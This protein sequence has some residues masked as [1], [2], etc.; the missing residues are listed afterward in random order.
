MPNKRVITIVCEVDQPE[1]N[2]IWENH[3]KPGTTHGVS[4]IGIANGNLMD[5]VS[6]LERKLNKA[7]DRD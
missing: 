5:E 7:L 4:V 1:A 6:D 2:W 3:L